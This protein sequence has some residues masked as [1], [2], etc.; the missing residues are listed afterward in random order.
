MPLHK[1]D[2]VRIQLDN[3]NS[4]Q[5]HFQ[6]SL[7]NEYSKNPG[8][9]MNDT[10]VFTVNP[11]GYDLLFPHDSTA[12]AFPGP[13]SLQTFDAE[14]VVKLQGVND[15]DARIKWVYIRYG[16]DFPGTDATD[17]T[18]VVA[19]ATPG[20]PKTGNFLTDAVTCNTPLLS[21]TVPEGTVKYR[22]WNRDDQGNLSADSITASG[23]S[24][25]GE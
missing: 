16:A 21:Q 6:D 19:E 13:D 12:T 1:I 4:T 22:A 24:L 20:S 8:Q 10:Q 7:R 9:V 18:P 17:G 5:L 2:L 3:D 23:T 25:G 15:F 14:G 11:N